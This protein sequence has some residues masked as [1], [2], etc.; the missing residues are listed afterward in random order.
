MQELVREWWEK[1]FFRVVAYLGFGLLSFALFLFWT[2]PDHRI[3]EI[4][5]NQAELLLDHEYEVSISDMGFWRLT[6]VQ[7]K[8]VNLEERVE[9]GNP[10]LADGEMPDQIGG[11]L[12]VRLEQ[13]AARFSPLRSL[14]NQGPAATF[15]AD[16]GGGVV[17]G[18]FVQSGNDQNIEFSFNN[19]DLQESTFLDSLLGVRLL[20][21]LDG[22]VELA[23]DAS[24]GLV[25]G[26]RVELT[27]EQVT[28]G[29]TTLE[30]DAIPFLTELDLPTTS[31]GNVDVV[32]DIEETEQGARV[33]FER[34]EIR[35][36]DIQAEV[37]GDI[38][39]TPRGGQ[40]RVEMRL[41]LN[42][43]YVSEHGLDRILTMS[44]FREGLY[45]SAEGNWYGFVISGQFGD[46]N[47]SGSRTAAQGPDGGDEGED[48][49]QEDDE[50][51]DDEE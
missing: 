49:E 10:S 29:A 50:Q 12:T 1:K 20:G 30:M 40:P 45:E 2:F 26:G 37:W 17:R 32:L 46:I 42:Q 41:Q 7:M 48:A 14:L 25:S 34:F 11:G 4:T 36:R 8:G 24:T 28:L 22:D 35:G 31:F 9:P 38:E 21:A 3:K 47:F 44:D 18:Q 33:N 19:L 43:E 51:E 15:R 23:I 5:A 39:L 6:G 16:V 13:L 27:G